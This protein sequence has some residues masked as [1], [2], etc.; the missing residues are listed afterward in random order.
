MVWVLGEGFLY[1]VTKEDSLESRHQGCSAQGTWSLGYSSQ[2]PSPQQ[3]GCVQVWALSH[4]WGH[5]PAFRCFWLSGY[6]R[7]G[8]PRS[9]RPE[10]LQ[11]LPFASDG[12]S[13]I[14]QGVDTL[15]G[16]AVTSLRPVMSHLP[17]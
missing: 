14:W 4:G 3:G 10:E 6:C 11:V 9:W 16:S 13:G 12:S 5:L 15:P 1:A 2:W 17:T 8:K 7:A